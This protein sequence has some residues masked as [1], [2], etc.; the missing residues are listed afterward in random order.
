MPEGTFYS[1]RRVSGSTP[2]K[3]WDVSSATDRMMKKI[4]EKRR[5]RR[6][7]LKGY[8]ADIAVGHIVCNGI[9][10]DISV[11]GLRLNDLPTRFL[12]ENKKYHV[13]VS[14]GTDA[15][16]YKLT[17]CPRWKRRTE[18]GYMDI[19]FHINDA[20]AGWKMFVRG[21]MEQGKE[22][23]EEDIWDQYNGSCIG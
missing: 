21:M 19:G 8:L 12:I 2:G 9:V 14:G 17:V 4:T 5:Q 10:G 15:V 13:V 20:P 3:D 23:Y 1:D 7:Q 22:K 11:E 16:C 18:F 6:M